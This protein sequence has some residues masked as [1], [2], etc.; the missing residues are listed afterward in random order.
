MHIKS[1]YIRDFGI[2]NNVTLDDISQEIV[3][4][5]GNNRAGKSTLLDIL[6]Y[7][8]Y[9][10]SKSMNIPPARIEY[11]VEGKFV[12][13]NDEEF[14]ARVNGYSK[15]HIFKGLGI[16]SVEN[17][18]SDVDIFTYKEIFTISLDELKYTDKEDEKLQSVLLGAGLK[19][20]ISVPRMISDFKAQAEKIGG[21]NGN[22]R[23]KLF[24]DSYN[25][26]SQGLNLQDKVLTQVEKYNNDINRISFI[27]NSI[28]ELEMEIKTIEDNIFITEILKVNYELYRKTDE[29]KLIL[30]NYEDKLIFKQIESSNLALDTCQSLRDQYDLVTNRYEELKLIFSK[31]TGAS[32]YILKCFKENG[33]EI[34]DGQLM[35]SGI[36]Q[37]IENYKIMLDECRT[38]K[39]EI[40]VDATDINEEWK[41]DFTKILNI[42]TEE[43]PFIQLS[44]NIDELKLVISKIEAI[45]YNIKQ[46]EEKLLES[47]ISGASATNNMFIKNI[48]IVCL[49]IIIGFAVYN[50]NKIFGVLIS[51]GGIVIA[52]LNMIFLAK[53]M[54]N[55]GANTNINTINLD[56]SKRKKE[57]I[58]LNDK[59]D[60]LE[61]LIRKY[62]DL[63]KLKQEVP[64]SSIKIY[65]GLV[66]E[67]KKKVLHLKYDLNNMTKLEKNIDLELGRLLELLIKFNDFLFIDE[68]KVR[69]NLIEN[70]QYIFQNVKKLGLLADKYEKLSVANVAK[71]IMEEKIMETLGLKENVNILESINVNIDKCKIFNDYKT[72]QNEYKNLKNQLIHS[73]EIER[74]KKTLTK[75]NENVE[76]FQRFEKII[77]TYINIEDIKRDESELKIK[78]ETKINDLTHLKDERTSLKDEVSRLCSS[79]DIILAHKKIE[80]GRRR[81]KKV[82]EDYA[83]NNA[84]AFILQLLQNDFIQGA[85]DTIF[86][87]TSK[88]LSDITDGQFS[89]VRPVDNLIKTDFMTMDKNGALNESMKSL[90]RGT[91]EQLFLSVRL[92]RIA[93]IKSKLPVIIDDSLV[94]FDAKHLNNSIRLISEL[95]KTNQIFFLTCHSDVVKAISKINKKVQFFKVD[96][97]KFSSSSKEGLVDY[98]EGGIV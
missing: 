56:I 93:E 72:N 95:S 70:S 13:D 17:V 23:I 48:I 80:N 7:F 20:V 53:T 22:P 64:T 6:R 16:E 57:L 1:L 51:M 52:A 77:N 82:A 4:I 31:E 76:L 11:E 3:V 10:F 40:I 43:I 83:V 98:L 68:L 41:E 75:D 38:A 37:K 66:R 74:V 24:K 81:F 8:P 61:A 47:N 46:F 14:I 21:K 90:S 97:G 49:F 32:D 55:S 89:E 71:E 54:V 63:L 78:Y 87:G 25:E 91:K 33:K 42:N 59:K 62:K 94:N 96:E 15:P 36:T 5:G 85:K 44:E 29:L 79:E 50:F 19:E 34:L 12:D 2:Y 35:I 60:S 26:I 84:A 27:E 88:I 30:N 58:E 69:K 92:S 28:D 86:N 18:Y 65:F 67:I 39:H 9:G 73:L 45:N